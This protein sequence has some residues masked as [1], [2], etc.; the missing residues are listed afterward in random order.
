MVDNSRE[1]HRMMIFSNDS[2]AVQSHLIKGLV[3]KGS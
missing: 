3:N 1:E 2:E